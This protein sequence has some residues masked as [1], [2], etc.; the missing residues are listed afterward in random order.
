LTNGDLTQVYKSP[1]AVA[2]LVLAMISFF[3]FFGGERK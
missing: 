2:L 3:G 1:V